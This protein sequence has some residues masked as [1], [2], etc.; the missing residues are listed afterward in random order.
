MTPPLNRAQSFALVLGGGAARGGAHI[1]TLR[2]LTEADLHPSLVVGVS[3][4]AVVGALYC[5]DPSQAL[6]QLLSLA[7]TLQET[8]TSLPLPLR[9]HKVLSLFSLKERCRIFTALGLHKVTFG[10]LQVPFLVTAT[11]LWPPGRS[12]LGRNPNVPVLEAVLAST[13]LPSRLPLRVRNSLYLDGGLS[14]NL[15]VRVAQAAGAKTI[16][17]VN[18]GFL[19]AKGKGIQRYLPWKVINTLGQAQMCKERRQCERSGAQVV[20]IYSEAIEE[21]SVLAFEKVDKFV[22]E[23]YKATL[24]IIPRLVKIL[25]R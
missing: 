22:E 9:I 16:L 25:T 23:G 24:R 18:L 13:A 4:G 17:A 2:A 12:I 6:S 21:E 3:I 14:G 11:R 19:F 15:P 5:L 8:C 1:G 20:E 10:Q 7:R